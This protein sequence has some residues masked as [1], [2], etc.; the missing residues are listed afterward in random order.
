[1]LS[2]LKPPVRPTTRAATTIKVVQKGCATTKVIALYKKSNEA[3]RTLLTLATIKAP[4]ALAL[5]ITHIV[6]AAAKTPVSILIAVAFC[7]T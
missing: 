6:A 4:K 1:M 3:A 7:S 5:Y 2:L